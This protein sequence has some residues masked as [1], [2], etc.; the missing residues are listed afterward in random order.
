MRFVTLPLPRT[1]PARSL[2]AAALSFTF[3]FPASTLAQATPTS[4]ATLFRNVRVFDGERMLPAQDVLIDGGMVVRLGQSVTA[5]AG[6]AVV[7]GAGR[8]LL[9]GLIDAH[10]H[11][12]DDALQQAV[13][14][15]V[16]THLDMFS[17]F[18]FAKEMRTAQ[19]AGR[20]TDRA[21]LFSAGTMV[22][23]PRGHGT[24]FGM[25]IP[26]ITSPDS[27]QAF[28]DARIAEGSD[29]IKIAYDDGR[30]YG[31]G[32]PTVDRATLQAVIAA[33]KRRGKL[34]LVH[35]GDAS[36]ARTA[37][38]VGASGL[39]HLFTDSTAGDSFA[40]QVAERNAFVIPTL[41]VLKSITGVGGGAPLVE[42]ARLRE[43]LLPASRSSLTQAF[44]RRQGAPSLEYSVAQSTVRALHTQGV[45][46]LAGSDAQ[47]PGTAYGA[48]LHR[49]LELLVEAGLTPL[50]ALSSATAIPA[51]AFSLRDRG[52][53]APNMRADLLLV[54]GDPSSDIT[55]TRAIVGVWKSGV[56]VNRASFAQRV[57][58][59]SVRTTV[60]RESLVNGLVSDFDKGT[61]SA[62]LGI[63]FPSPD[64]MAGGTSTGRLQVVTGGANG[65]SH[66]LA[67]SGTITNK[68]PY[69][70]YGAMW[71][72]GTPP[73]SPVD[74]AQYKGLRFD[75]QGD[76][77]TYRV[78]VFAQSRGTAPITR[79]F[80]ADAEWRTVE[81]TWEQF[82]ID[83]RDVTGVVL[84]GGPQPGE[85]AFR[86][87]G[88]RLIPGASPQ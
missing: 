64:N 5:P 44:P 24:Q 71:T 12:F 52:R 2:F 77:K 76:G 13:I 81:V 61:L 33:A 7:D 9:P 11:S 29:W 50:E 79:T 40:K 47:N 78:M 66:A 25:T 80:V 30:A 37:I 19:D 8:T 62:A 51:R 18:A 65:S 60:S 67:V 4:G 58:A 27:A 88:F 57:A 70:W 53:I 72:P 23:A 46:I 42:D 59:L 16:T 69:A 84:A 28:V 49:E 20:A 87:D 36:S 1:F 85:F 48:A 38:D 31:M 32:M 56:P 34:A 15:G 74:L 83:G 54:T 68:V 82:G 43:Y 17:D 6:A 86:V 39:V 75:A 14:F 22:T 3:A 35:V 10:T 26:T 45:P 21:D 73:M 63:W 55:A 41:V